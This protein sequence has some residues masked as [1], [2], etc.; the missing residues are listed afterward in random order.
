MRLQDNQ[1]EL[2]ASLESASRA[3]EA[4]HAAGAA[5]ELA[6]AVFAKGW[7]TYRLGEGEAALALGER[8][9][10]LSTA[11]GDQSEI[12]LSL[13]LLGAAHDMLGHL[14]E[15]R[16]CTERALALNRESGSLLDVASSLNNLGASARTRGDYEAARAYYEEALEIASKIAFRWG[17]MSYRA[18]LGGTWVGLGEY[19]AAERLL[20]QVIDLPEASRWVG[21]A[22][23]YRFLAEACLGQGQ[24]EAALAAVRRA[25]DLAQEHAH[26][27][28][29]GAAWRVLGLVAARLPA[30]LV[31]GARI[32]SAP[33]CFGESLRIFTEMGAE[34]E[35]ARTLRAWAWYALE[36]GQPE[37]ERLWEEAWLTFTRLG[38]D[39]EAQRMLGGDPA[40]M[41]VAG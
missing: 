16:D 40:V 35:R 22:A 5:A 38:M 8:S 26:R 4:A 39:L 24:P 6:R 34:G 36:Q 30:P 25:L 21:L 12:A 41:P 10:A 18:S 13:N 29:I 33:A 37:G 23:A 32:Y 9:L 20:R 31:L 2:R 15:A 17:E 11:L 27:E 1:S 19:A 7:A 28:H 14:E 3:E